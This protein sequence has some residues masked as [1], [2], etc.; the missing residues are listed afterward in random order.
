MY[1]CFFLLAATLYIHRQSAYLVGR[2]R[3]V[4][5]QTLS[6]PYVYQ[7]WSC[8][9]SVTCPWTTHRVPNNM[10][11]CSIDWWSTPNPMETMGKESGRSSVTY[12]CSKGPYIE[13][14]Y[15][16]MRLGGL[17]KYLNSRWSIAEAPRQLVSNSSH[18]FLFL[19]PYL[20]D[21]GSTNGSF[22]ND[23]KIEQAKYYELKEKVRER[24]FWAK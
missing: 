5:D 13:I 19:R 17:S 6:F 4:S 11:C 24:D 23:Q 18:I 21:L 8:F 15:L 10:Q 22:I 20:I 7:D 12:L 3:R 9:R 14:K 1:W 16:D 2:D